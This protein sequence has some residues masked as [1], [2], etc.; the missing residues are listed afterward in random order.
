M[1][2]YNGI[3]HSQQDTCVTEYPEEKPLGLHD[4]NEY[5]KDDISQSDTVL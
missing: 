4:F 2:G 1:K 5:F 3:M